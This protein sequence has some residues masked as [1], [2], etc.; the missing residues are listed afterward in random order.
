VLRRTDESS[1]ARVP[2]GGLPYAL[3]FS[4]DGARAY[5]AASGSDTVVASTASRARWCA[6]PHGSRTVL[7]RA[8]PDGKSV[9][10]VNRRD[11][12]L[13][14]HD[15]RSLSLRGSVPVVAHPR[16]SVMAD[17]SVAFVLS[18]TEPRLSVVICGA[19]CC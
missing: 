19:A 8:T 15:A 2:V 6:R 10:V 17:N 14:I 12:T 11:A 9:L 16:M 1:G 4:P 7:A 5:A 13:G 3:D 18:R